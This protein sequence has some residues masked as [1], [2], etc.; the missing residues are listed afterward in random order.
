MKIFNTLFI[1]LLFLAILTPGFS[2]VR[3][4]DPVFEEVE[5]TS[6]LTYGVNATVLVVS[7]FGEAIPEGLKMDFYEPKGDTVSERPLVILFHT[8]N[9]L[10]QQI[11]RSV[12]GTRTDSSNV[13]IATRL[14]KMGYVVAAVDY[15]LGWD[16]T[17]PTQPERALQLIQ[18]AYRGVQDAR[19][20]IRYFKQDADINN[21]SFGVDT[22]R[23]TLWGVGTGGYVSLATAYLNDF[24]D[25][26]LTENP[27]A[28]FLLDTNGDGA[29]ET[30]MIVPQING[31]IYG[32]SVGVFPLTT[33]PFPLGD[34]LCYPNHVGYNSDFQLCVNTAGALGDLAWMDEGDIPVINYHAPLDFFA[35]YNDG[36]LIVPTTGD[37][38]V[39][40]QGGKGVATKA[41][42]LGINSSFANES[43]SFI[44]SYTQAAENASSKAGHDYIEG[45][46][47]IVR[48]LNALGNPEG[49][50]YQWWDPVFWSTKPFNDTTNFDQA[51]RLF[52]LDANPVK[53][54]LYIDTL[55][56]YF[57]PRAIFALNLPVSMDTLVARSIIELSVKT[58]QLP[59]LQVGLNI[60]PNPAKDLVQFTTKTEYPIQAIQIFDLSGR[61][62]HGQ[63]K[64][65]SN[66]YE[67]Y[68]NNLSSGIYVARLQFEGGIIT[69][70]IVFE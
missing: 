40:V 47:P 10:P 28:K 60:A 22:S 49:D 16:P 3:Y 37:R 5:V 38:I 43:F 6:G 33:G 14:A 20:A 68:R 64:M 45:L 63:S 53:A 9:F 1:C 58:K 42:E 32:T 35:P 51:S 59:A 65:N 25:I 27:Q 15:R 52:N 46:F 41:M 48:P 13:E 23:I 31:D 4:L 54:R 26:I 62:V 67:F 8:G 61:M 69:K 66:S 18:A 70:K 17:A 19:T 24:T 2:Q 36:V 50:P 7:L 30:P 12:F 55:I 44:D 11:N 56:G 29:P 39:Q 21:N 34:T 57:T